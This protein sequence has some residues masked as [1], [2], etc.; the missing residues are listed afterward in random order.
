MA[1]SEGE[2]LLNVS[3]STLRHNMI[4]L[5]Y[6]ESAIP[7]ARVRMGESVIVHSVDGDLNALCGAGKPPDWYHKDECWAGRNQQDKVTCPEC[8]RRT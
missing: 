4:A 3:E 6:I 5:C 8:K 7:A 1:N 2:I